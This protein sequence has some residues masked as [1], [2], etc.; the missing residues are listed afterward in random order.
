MASW[1]S[2]HTY[3]VFLQEAW[4]SGWHFVLHGTPAFLQ[5]QRFDVQ[6]PLHLQTV[7]ALADVCHPVACLEAWIKETSCKDNWS[8]LC[9]AGKW[10]VLMSISSSARNQFL[11][12]PATLYTLYIGRLPWPTSL[13]ESTLHGKSLAAVLVRSAWWILT[14]TVSPF[15]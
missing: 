3:Y 14:P 13:H 6:L 9:S 12:T 7:P 4:V 10:T 15:E 5:Q 8:T 11:I 2:Y 1:Q